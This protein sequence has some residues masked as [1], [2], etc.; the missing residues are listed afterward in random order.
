MITRSLNGRGYRKEQ[1][2]GILLACKLF[3][4]TDVLLIHERHDNS[5][6]YKQ[7]SHTHRETT[8]LAKTVE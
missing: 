8:S 6:N 2:C 7:D 4:R 3:L 5:R 1:A